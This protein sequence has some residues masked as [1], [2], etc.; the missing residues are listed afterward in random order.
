[1][2]DQTIAKLEPEKDLAGSI[3]FA[4]KRQEDTRSVLIKREP[5]QLKARLEWPE[6]HPQ[7][8]RKIRTQ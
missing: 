1:M 7:T 5:E 6:K 3:R 4:L 2:T 8:G